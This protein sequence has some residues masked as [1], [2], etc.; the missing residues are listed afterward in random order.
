MRFKAG[1]RTVGPALE[2]HRAELAAALTGVAEAQTALREAQKRLADREQPIDD[3]RDRLDVARAAQIRA[4]QERTA[5]I[6][7][8]GWRVKRWL[9]QPSG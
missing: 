8:L 1:F 7:A 9:D 5:I 4:E 3:L 6:G 2:H